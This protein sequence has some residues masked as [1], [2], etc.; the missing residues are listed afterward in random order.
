[1]NVCPPPS[2][3]RLCYTSKY[4]VLNS[5]YDSEWPHSKFGAQPFEKRVLKVCETCITVEFSLGLLV[6]KLTKSNL[7]C[8]VINVLK[9]SI[10]VNK[11]ND[12]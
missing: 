11:I 9:N 6:I 4:A 3:N 10:L 2:S 12:F 8:N 7:L 1:M 5:L